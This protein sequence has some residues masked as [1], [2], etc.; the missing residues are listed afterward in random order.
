MMSDSVFFVGHPAEKDPCIKTSY[1]LRATPCNTAGNAF[2]CVG[3]MT[4]RGSL[5]LL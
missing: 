3:L 5:P 2:S 4:G 1:I